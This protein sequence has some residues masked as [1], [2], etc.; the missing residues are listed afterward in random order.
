M[1]TLTEHV[2]HGASEIWPGIRWST[3]LRDRVFW[4]HGTAPNGREAQRGIPLVLVNDGKLTDDLSAACQAIADE[5]S[6]AFIDWTLV[7]CG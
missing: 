1:T 4:I 6:P 2:F 7:G 5:F 3:E